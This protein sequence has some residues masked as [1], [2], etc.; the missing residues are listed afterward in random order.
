VDTV[1]R[2]IEPAEAEAVARAAGLAFSQPFDKER[3]EASLETLEPDRTLAAWEGD[4]VVATAGAATFRL[5]VPGGHLGAA[6]VRNVGV[7][8]THRRR[9]LLTELMRRQLD[10]VRGRGEPLA[11]LWA[12]ESRIY[13]RF[14]YGLAALGMG[15]EAARARTEFL[16]GI[17]VDLP[18]RL[19]DEDELRPVMI[20]VHERLRHTRPGMVDRPP[21]WID[22]RLRRRGQLRHAVVEGPSGAEAYASY[23]VTPGWGVSGPEHDLFVTEALAVT[24]EAEGTIWRFIFDTDLVRTVRAGFRP[25]DEP[26]VLMLADTQAVHRRITDALW[27][28]LVDLE[29]A[30]KG[31]RYSAD[32]RL[33]LEVSDAFCPWNEGRWLLE[34]SHNGAR[35]TRTSARP[36]LS[37]DT[38]DLAATFLGGIG[39]GPLVRA[40]RVVERVGGAA[41]GAQRALAWDPPPWAVTFF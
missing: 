20:E 22:Y 19:V 17:P 37:M 24:P 29:A 34:G 41:A 4:T 9:G 10:D 32:V 11:C 25:I 39:V 21:P 26:L 40:G 16:P 12:S 1:I 36:D 38:A 30:L 14:G 6:G 33:V 27:V 18:V 28:R 7:L 31:R 2:T 35:C 8:P 15:W 13:R 23:Q 5:S 3:F